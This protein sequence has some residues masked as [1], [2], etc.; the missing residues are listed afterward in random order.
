MKTR[1]I[2][3]LPDVLKKAITLS[4]ILRGCSQAEVIRTA[5]YEHLRDL[6]KKQESKK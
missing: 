5:L 3:T 2:I 6:I 1:L 4:S